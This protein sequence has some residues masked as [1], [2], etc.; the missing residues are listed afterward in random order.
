MQDDSAKDAGGEQVTQGKRRPG[1]DS[2]RGPL[3][4]IFFLGSFSA[5]GFLLYLAVLPSDLEGRI[6]GP[7]SAARLVLM[8]G[9]FIGATVTFA[10]GL[11][12]SRNRD[13]G[14]RVALLI[15]GRKDIVPRI[16]VGS[17]LAAISIIVGLSLYRPRLLLSLTKYHVARLMP[18]Y[19][20]PVVILVLLGVA[21]MTMWSE[22]RL[23][24]PF[25]IWEPAAALLL[26]SLSLS[27]RYPLTSY[28]L[29]YQAVWDEVVTYT[30]ALSLIADP[31][32]A[33]VQSVPGYGLATYGELLIHTTAAGQVAGLLSGLRGQ[34]VSSIADFA[35]PPKGVGSIYEGVHKSG[36]PLRSPRILLALINS[37]APVLI[38]IALRKYLMAG[39]WPSFAGGLIYAIFSREVVYYSSYILPDALGTTISLGAMLAA[40]AA[41][42][43]RTGKRVPYLLCGAFV[44]LAVSVTIRYISLAIVPLLAVGVARDRAK[45]MTKLAAAFGGTLGAFV[46]AS[47]KALTDTAAYL[48][49]MTSLV[50]RSDPSI[51]NRLESLVFYTQRMFGSGVEGGGLGVITLLLALAGLAILLLSRPRY[52]LLYGSFG[53]VHLL[54][55][56]PIIERYSRHV[57]VLY[58][59]ACVLAGIGLEGIA[60]AINAFLAGKEGSL[61]LPPWA[62]RWQIKGWL[63]PA[64]VAVGFLLA[65]VF[66]TRMTVSYVKMM[67]DAETTQTSMAQYL[68]QSLRS[69]ERV[70]ILDLIPW[71]EADLHARGIDFERIGLRTTLAELRRRGITHVVGTDAIEGE[72][73]PISGT[74]WDT[75]FDA[76]GDRIAEF[77]NGRLRYRGYPMGRLYLFAAR[78]PPVDPALGG[79]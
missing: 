33:P 22:R 74:I 53:V 56:T 28:G 27:V 15:F 14:R 51:E 19:A 66:H 67:A 23:R 68:E 37:A 36:L 46:V 21:W 45:L 73:D 48:M 9:P 29:P 52:A 32:A 57:L 16:L 71:V 31:R 65:A 24:L 60:G 58:P 13:W 42:N 63:G 35:A 78:V 64:L 2:A 18:Y 7:Y 34:K 79:E 62:R 70:G 8:S 69:G 5:L 76:P 47:P 10:L 59:L 77:G 72:Y 39:L 4:T 44:G 75:A 26:F 38:F 3:A 55:V 12:A 30:R 50:W 25:G 6:L 11:R 20:W 1:G 40:M 17:V 49:G 54:I 61:K 41:V 43:D